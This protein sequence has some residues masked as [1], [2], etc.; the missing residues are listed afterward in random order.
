M[1]TY[2]MIENPVRKMRGGKM[3]KK[4]DKKKDKAKT[5]YIYLPRIKYNKKA[6]K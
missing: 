3:T 2:N 5:K 6:Q 1:I 4:K